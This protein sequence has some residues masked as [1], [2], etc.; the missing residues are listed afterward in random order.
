M[1][2][3]KMPVKKCRELRRR[4]ALR[5]VGKNDIGTTSNTSTDRGSGRPR[6]YPL[7]GRV[8]IRYLRH[9]EAKEKPIGKGFD[10]IPQRQQPR[11]R[12]RAV[13]AETPLRRTGKTVSNREGTDRSGLYTIR[14]SRTFC[15]LRK[16][17]TFD[18]LINCFE[19]NNGA[20]CEVSTKTL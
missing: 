16:V 6:A 10:K 9:G 4:A 2:V 18:V 20:A 11:G 12:S 19:A 3:T 14:K 8:G 1:G 17:V 5:G 7:R 13:A 15:T